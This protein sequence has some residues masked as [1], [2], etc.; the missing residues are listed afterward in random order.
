[1]LSPQEEYPCH[2]SSHN[3]YM[4]DAIKYKERTAIKGKY[5]CLSPKHVEKL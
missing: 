2:T 1:M 3:L 5:R 4:A